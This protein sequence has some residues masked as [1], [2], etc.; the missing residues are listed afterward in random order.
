M[1]ST[2]SKAMVAAGAAGSLLFIAPAAMASVS[3]PAHVCKGLQTCNGATTLP[4]P[5]AYTPPAVSAPGG[6]SCNT[7]S[8]TLVY[9]PKTVT[10]QVPVTTNKTYTVPVTTYVTK[11]TTV[12][13]AYYKISNPDYSCGCDS[14]APQY[15]YVLQST[16]QCYVTPGGALY[17]DDGYTRHPFT[18]QLGSLHLVGGNYMP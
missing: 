11:T 8:A 15:V 13:V 16:G 4:A 12:Q 6:S 1:L 3:S 5:P 17:N 2:I 14:S 7:C 10:T 9:V 18:A